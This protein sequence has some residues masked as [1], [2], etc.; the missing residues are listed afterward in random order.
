MQLDA[1]GMCNALYD[2]QAVVDAET[3][4]EL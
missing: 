3:I 1:F 4:E 2:V